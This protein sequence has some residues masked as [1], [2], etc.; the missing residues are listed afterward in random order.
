MSDKNL[1]S[2]IQ[3]LRGIAP[4]PTRSK[5]SEEHR[6]TENSEA[7]TEN[8]EAL[9]KFLNS[10]SALS[11]EENTAEKKYTMDDLNNFIDSLVQ[12]K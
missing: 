1:A 6:N 8:K 7:K 9:E 10:P 5:V 3:R 12:P 4:S 2:V 11:A